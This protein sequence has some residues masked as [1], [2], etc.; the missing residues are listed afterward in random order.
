MLPILNAITQYFHRVRRLPGI[1]VHESFRSE[2][3]LFFPATDTDHIHSA[4]E[5]RIDYSEPWIFGFEYSR[6]ED[7]FSSGIADVC[8]E[9]DVYR[10]PDRQSMPK[11]PFNK[12][13][14]I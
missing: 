1:Q 12:L 6:P 10:H 13:H 8:L 5:D 7:F 9:R 14:D 11:T 4:A 3:I 2:N